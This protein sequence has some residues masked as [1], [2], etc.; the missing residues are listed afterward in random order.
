ML[1]P[2]N[3]NY[4][5]RRLLDLAHLIN[6]CQFKTPACI[7]Y[8]IHGCEP[9]HSDFGEHGKS[10]AMKAA[11][12]QHVASCHPCHVWFGEKHKPRAELLMI[13]NKARQRTFDLY[14]K[15]RLLAAVGYKREA[16]NV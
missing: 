3:I 6:E 13:F 15:E 10:M 14:A 9:A 12:D 16:S 8:Q 2:K 11:D 7:G 1:I 4:R 5:N